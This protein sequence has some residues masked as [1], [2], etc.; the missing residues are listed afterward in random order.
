MKENWQ[1]WMRT[2]SLM[3]L[4]SY[5]SSCKQNDKTT[6]EAPSGKVIFLINHQVEGQQ[7]KRVLIQENEELQGLAYE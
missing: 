2:I 4:M 7:L 3:M 5:V 1:L 6:P